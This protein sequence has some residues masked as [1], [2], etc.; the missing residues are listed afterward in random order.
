MS[1]ETEPAASPEV[2]ESYA[3]DLIFYVNGERIL[4]RNVDPTIL[5]VDYLR[6]TPVG[7]TGTKKVCAQGGCGACTVMLSEY[8]CASDEVKHRAI[9][10]CL[11]PLCSLDG[12]EVTTTEG[13]GSV[14]TALSPVQYR[15]AKENGSQC[16]FCTPGFVMNMHS[17]LAAS[18]GRGLTQ[19]QIE[20][21]F[22]G[23]ICRCT[24]YRPILYAMK[25]FASDWT[26]EDEKGSMKCEVDPA[27]RVSHQRKLRVNF[28]DALK[29]APR[30]V[31]YSDKGYH[32]IRPLTLAELY[33]LVEQHPDPQNVRL[34]CGNTSIGVYDKYV[35]N[36]HVL[37]DIS[38]VA[39]LK[40]IEIG[41]N[42]LRLGATVTYSEF[43]ET[44]DG[45]LATATE[46]QRAGLQA[47]KYLAGRTAGT[48][49]RN[50]ASLAGNTMMVLR[51]I[52]EGAPFPSDLFTAF[53][54][55]GAVLTVGS[56]KWQEP[57]EFPI[58]AFAEE[59]AN[60]VELQRDAVLLSYFVPFTRAG[61]YAETYKM[62][63]RHENSHSIVNAGFRVLLGEG[64]VVKEASLVF[65]G[66]SPLAFHATAAQDYLIGKEWNA[67]TLSGV[68]AALKQEAT[69]VIEKYRERYSQ[70][71]F[72]GFTDGYRRHL[73]ESF[74]Y[75]FFVNVSEQVAPDMI[76][77]AISSAGER[78]ERPVSRGTQRYKFYL[79]EYP[80]NRPF[81][82]IEAFLQ[83]TGEAKYTHDIALPARGLEGAFVTSTQ[84]VGKISYRIPDGNGGEPCEVGQLVAWLKEQRPEFSDYITYADIPPDGKNVQGF[85]G[86]DPLFAP[87]EVT[88][89][90]QSIG[91][92]VAE[93]EQAAQDIANFVQTN[94]VA[95]D[96]HDKTGKEIEPILT[97]EDA[98]AKNSIFTDCPPSNAFM[99]HIWKITRAGSNLD[100]ADTEGDAVVD[101]VKCRV[102]GGSQEAGAQVHFY[103]E[104]QSCVAIPGE[105]RE[106]VVHP[107]SQS[108]DEL[109]AGVAATLGIHSN[110]IDVRIKRVGGAYGGKTT[111]SPFVASPTALAAWKLKR[112]VRVAMRREEDTAMI[113]K[114][115]PILGEYKLAIATGEDNP[116]HKGKIVGMQTS[117]WLDGGNTYDASFVVMDVIQLRCDSAY[118]VK[119]YETQGDV[120]KTNKASNT[121]F[122]SMGMIQAT[123]VQEDAIERAA[124]AVGML[125]EDVR[126]K[127]L[128]RLGD[129][130]PFGQLLDDCYMADV[131]NYLVKKCDFQTRLEAVR[132]FNAENRWRKRGISMLPVK[133][134]SGYN[135][136]LLEQAGALVEVYDQ[137]GTVLVRHGGVEMG[138]GLMT[139]VAQIAAY[140]LNV[141]LTFINMSDTDTNVVPNPTS[142]GASTGAAFN[143]GAVRDACLQLRRRL[144]DFCLD[145]LKENGSQWCQDN[146]IN[147]WDYP[148]G[149]RTPVP[150]PAPAPEAAFQK[151]APKKHV[152]PVLI[153]NKIVSLAYVNRVDLSA[154]V[155]FKQAGGEA[156]DSGLTFKSPKCTEPVNHFTGFTYSAACTEVEVDVLTGETT[157][158]RSD[159]MYDV[160]KSI[161]PAIDVGQVEGGFIQGLGYVLTEDVIFQP[162]G[163]NK[164]ALNTLNTWTYKPPAASTIPLEFHV[165]LYPREDSAEAPENPYDLLSSKEVGEP[166]LVLA[167]T[168]FFAIKHAVLDARRDRG[169]DEWFEMESP[170]TVQRVREACLVEADDLKI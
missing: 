45:T 161:N 76:P 15:V 56:A 153:W 82:K 69:A 27:E 122:R 111:R 28:P 32:W 14:N 20:G 81:I 164:G 101:G 89:F 114:R 5:L 128:Y 83:A 71:P 87:G 68:V 138:Q 160:G 105:H 115:H 158:L 127:N 21:S 130:T 35:E 110:L 37:I 50:A 49:V 73:V 117:F 166:P 98:I 147:F 121:A 150:P 116:E 59:Y 11:R 132:Q 146:H 136:T 43:I 33:R 66:L 113:G 140:E 93:T 107:S 143:G 157:I 70:F 51:H 77:P 159:V 129:T 47:L 86:D 163:E 168:A 91:L 135:L 139:K 25:H 26:P 88:C 63:L 124:H 31:H 67:E 120:C 119:N 96:K 79:D 34:V 165:D 6:S 60:S 62:S 137:D 112:A 9:N 94:C 65:G 106:I 152:E 149:W 155:R 109:H 92:V 75:K 2:G 3:D 22:D 58:H 30:A 40:E 39:E 167:A 17:L 80:V 103:M 84:P 18:E 141:P 38:H 169:H 97:I 52:N 19:Q 144:E 99:V 41:D 48:I 53:C 44:L 29:R 46:E 151:P 36:P 131:W 8:D 64:N 61:E 170:A 154:Q 85:G 1:R 72:E 133:Y 90:G 123:L 118:M 104:S 16:G 78:A 145:L 10:S 23:N 95:Y 54:A 12:M 4:V 134:A 148:T 142:T 55:A 42:G 13:T 162:D 7:L 156:M 74:F 24:G 108:P 125:A 102:V 126:G 100:W 57:R